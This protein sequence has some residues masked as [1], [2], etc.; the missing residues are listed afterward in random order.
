LK[1]ISKNKEKEYEREIDMKKIIS[2]YL[3]L[4][5][6][7]LKS[8]DRSIFI[9]SLVKVNEDK[10]EKAIVEKMQENEKLYTD[11]FSNIKEEGDLY[12]YFSKILQTIGQKYDAGKS[13]QKIENS[14]NE[15]DKNFNDCWVKFRNIYKLFSAKNVFT[16]KDKYK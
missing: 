1:V 8:S 14:T 10:N 4:V 7:N 12:K 15:I 3:R 5:I 6:R 16:D 2:L 9:Q 11:C 13:F